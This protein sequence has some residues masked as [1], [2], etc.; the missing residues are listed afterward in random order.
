MKSRGP[1]QR[2]LRHVGTALLCAAAI[3]WSAC[4][5]PSGNAGAGPRLTITESY[6]D[7]PTRVATLQVTLVAEGP[8]LVGLDNVVVSVEPPVSGTEKLAAILDDASLTRAD[9]ASWPRE[10]HMLPAEAAPLLRRIQ[11]ALWI[12]DAPPGDST[13]ERAEVDIFDEQTSLGLTRVRRE[14]DRIELSALGLAAA[15]GN[16]ALGTAY[17]VGTV[18]SGRADLAGTRRVFGTPAEPVRLQFERQAAPA[19]STP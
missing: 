19:A 11:L 18:S 7:P 2:L 17:A 8:N 15:D 4:D 12:L 6:G 1:T 5:A 9:A 14:G 16:D 3:A 10:A 13:R